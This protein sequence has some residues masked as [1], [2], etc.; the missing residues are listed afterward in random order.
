MKDLLRQR[1]GVQESIM[2]LLNEQIKMEAQASAGYLAMAAWCD[3]NNFDNS[4][5]FFYK[6]SS[7]ERDHM[8]KIFR[9]V[10]DLGGVAVSP[11]VEPS[12]SDFSSLQEVFETT[13]EN[14]I[15][16]TES[17]HQLVAACRQAN[18]YATENFLQWFVA[19][20]IE[21]E[22]TVKK[23]LGYFELIGDEPT[24]LLII[25]ERVGKASA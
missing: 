24:S 13:L 22:N 9:F 6:Q 19:E 1:V 15:A 21:E 5:E 7:E 8:M 3:Q 20:Q 16:V 10:S 14:E 17:I 18:D 23:I 4:A 12:K 11:D 2:A 25:D